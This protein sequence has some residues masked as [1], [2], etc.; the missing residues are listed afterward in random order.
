[1]Q[2]SDNRKPIILILAGS[3]LLISMCMVGLALFFF[4]N[5]TQAPGEGKKATQG[6]TLCAPIIEALARYHDAQGSYPTNLEALIPDYLAEIPT[7]ENGYPLTYTLEGASYVLQF[8]Y[9]G[10]GMNECAYRPETG[11]KCQGYF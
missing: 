5:A 8:N 7:P 6:Y 1:M 11:W 10:P 3:A 2:T 9:T 4:K